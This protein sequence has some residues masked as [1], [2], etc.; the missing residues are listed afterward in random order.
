MNTAVWGR[1]LERM[2]RHL[3]LLDADFDDV[4]VMF[5]RST[6]VA[7]EIGTGAH[8][9]DAYELADDTIVVH[10]S[11]RVSARERLRRRLGDELAPWLFE[12]H[13][14][15]GVPCFR[16]AQLELVLRAA[17]YEEALLQVGADLTWLA[18]PDCLAQ[19]RPG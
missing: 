8:A 13:D 4:C 16:A 12:H 7:I 2:H 6:P 17:S 10:T 5:R 1:E 3:V 14:G 9:R 19:T 15:R 18:I 11:F